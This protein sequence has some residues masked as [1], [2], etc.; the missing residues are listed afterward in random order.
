MDRSTPAKV[1]DTTNDATRDEALRRFMQRHAGRVPELGRRLGAAGFS[2]ECTPR[3]A[4][5]ER[6]GLL[7]KS[8]LAEYQRAA[9]RLGGL[10]PEGRRAPALFSLPGGIVGPMADGSVARLV[11]QLRDGVVSRL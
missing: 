4:E 1:P 10:V 3:W 5:L 6:V 8:G 11:E 2:R 7:R 9:P